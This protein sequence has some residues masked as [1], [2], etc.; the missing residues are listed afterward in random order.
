[1][2]SSDFELLARRYDRLAG[3]FLLFMLCSIGGVSIGLTW[4]LSR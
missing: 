2:R 1:M 3:G 4:L